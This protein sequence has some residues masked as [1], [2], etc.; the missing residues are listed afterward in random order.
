[1]RA[2]SSSSTMLMISTAAGNPL[3]AQSSLQS[4]NQYGGIIDVNVCSDSG[5][6]DALFGNSGVGLALGTAEEVDCTKYSG[7][8]QKSG[9][10][11]SVASGK[12]STATGLTSS[13]QA[14]GKSGEIG[15]GGNDM[16]ASWSVLVLEIVAA[17]VL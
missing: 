16:R 6:R 17:M 14:T 13:A 4:T 10:G 15:N 3:C 1:V 2:R 11:E 9:T 5:A 12:G 7:T 8:I